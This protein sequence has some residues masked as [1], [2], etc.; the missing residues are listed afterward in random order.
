MSSPMILKLP[1]NVSGGQVTLAGKPEFGPPT[2]S[3]AAI[4]ALKARLAAAGPKQRKALRA[5]LNKVRKIAVRQKMANFKNKLAALM[6]MIRKVRASLRGAGAAAKVKIQKHLN[7]LMNQFFDLKIGTGKT[8]LAGVNTRISGTKRMLVR[9]KDRLKALIARM[10]RQTVQDPKLNTIKSKLQKAVNG[11]RRAL[12]TAQI[13]KKG[14][15][16]Y[17][18]KWK[19]RKNIY[20]KQLMLKKA[21]S[22][23]LGTIPGALKNIMAEIKRH[24]KILNNLLGKTKSLTR[25]L[26]KMRIKRVKLGKRVKLSKNGLRCLKK[27]GS[28]RK[29]KLKLKL[30]RGHIS[31]LKKLP[32]TDKRKARLAL[33]R[34]RAKFHRRRIHLIIKCRRSGS[35]RLRCRRKYG[36]LRKHKLKLKLA[37]GHIS[38]LKKLPVTDKRKARLALWHKRARFHRRRIYQIWKCT[39]KRFNIC[40]KKYGSLRR[41]KVTLKLTRRRIF[42]LKKL[43]VTDKRKARLVL[44]R[45]RARFHRRRIHLIWACACKRARRL[46]KYYKKK[47][48]TKKSPVYRRRMNKHRRMLRV[49]VC[50]KHRIMFRR[51]KRNYYKFKK[52]FIQMPTN[53]DAQENRKKAWRNMIRHREKL[54]ALKCKNLPRLRRRKLGFIK[55]KPKA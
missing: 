21:A 7:R 24:R 46:F 13:K 40:V 26:K 9:R 2:T 39:G 34:K 53:L 10:K 4:S 37:R 52:M 12:A 8:W 48:A 36:S 55:W 6:K 22:S 47:Y 51:A 14:I 17:V 16:T 27:Y 28:M 42:R 49:C 50:R 45:K 43:P 29:H 5:Q 1:L 15:I 41:H 32:V 38:K 33:W 18:N 23:A 54:K 30:A 31:K 19:A 35:R 20:N 11:T 3:K 44:L 25:S